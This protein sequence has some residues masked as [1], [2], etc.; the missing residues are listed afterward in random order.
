[1]VIS[2]LQRHPKIAAGHIR[3][4][5]NLGAMLIEILELY[6][7]RFNFDRVGIAIDDG[8]SYF[9]KLSFQAENQH[10]WKRI[11]IR[12][13]N[14]PNNNIAKASH[15][16]DNIIKVFSDAFRELTARCYIVHA[17]IKNGDTAPWGTN[18]G[19]ILDAIVE[20]PQTFVRKRLKRVWEEKL[21][22][23][24]SEDQFP[25]PSD[26]EKSI[27]NPDK[28][29]KPNRPDPRA[30]RKTPNKR[31][32]KTRPNDN[33]KPEIV[34]PPS[35]SSAKRRAPTAVAVGES[36]DSPILLE[37]SPE[38]S[39]PR[40]TSRRPPS[41]TEK[42][43][44]ASKNADRAAANLQTTGSISGTSRNIISIN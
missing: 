23:F 43:L 39:S 16:S 22:G 37:S 24:P 1:M 15:Q 18:C 27:A 8:G 28:A 21:A 32:L 38:P 9:D 44:S 33:G 11:C 26:R 3:A 10:V 31:E 42:N 20:R 2:F 30:V 14:D 12:D 41:P 40:F 34:F 36:K 19:S 13:P 5:D 29:M 25:A 35:K 6:G 4:E 7:L 17:R